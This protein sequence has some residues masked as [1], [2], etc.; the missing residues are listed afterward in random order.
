PG[1]RSRELDL[2]GPV[3]II[4]GVRLGPVRDE[5]QIRAALE[6]RRPLG[7]EVV[8]GLR[9]AGWQSAEA[10]LG[11]SEGGAPATIAEG[12]RRVSGDRL[13]RPGFLPGLAVGQPGFAEAHEP[14]WPLQAF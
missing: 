13:V 10:A 9:S 11:R 8:L 3:A 4:R 12:V 7:L 2:R 6:L 14:E 1:A 5:A